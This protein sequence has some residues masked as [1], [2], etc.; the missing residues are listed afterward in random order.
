MNAK[1]IL[2]EFRV[3]K[4]GGVERRLLSTKRQ[5]ELAFGGRD[6]TLAELQKRVPDFQGCPKFYIRHILE[7]WGIKRVWNYKYRILPYVKQTY[8]KKK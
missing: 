1:E 3:R 2:K 6:V 8:T 7:C 5:I 4:Y